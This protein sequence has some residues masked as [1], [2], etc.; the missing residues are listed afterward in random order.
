MALTILPTTTHILLR[1]SAYILRARTFTRIQLRNSQWDLLALQRQ[2]APCGIFRHTHFL[3]AKKQKHRYIHVIMYLLY[4]GGAK[5]GQKGEIEITDQVIVA[6][7]NQKRARRTIGENQPLLFRRGR[8]QP[9]APT[10][11][12]RST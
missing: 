9:K 5:M 8:K 1:S 11:S 3:G 12:R 2:G 4:R 7:N 6:P 10:N